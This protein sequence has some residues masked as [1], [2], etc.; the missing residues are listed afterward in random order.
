MPPQA[1]PYGEGVLAR[2]AQDPE[3][4][5]LLERSLW[6]NAYMSAAEMRRYYESEFVKVKGALDDL[7]LTRQCP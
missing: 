2:F 7:G 6:A 1:G 5:K 3:W 4:Q